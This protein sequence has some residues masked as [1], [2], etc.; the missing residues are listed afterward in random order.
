MSLANVPL[1]N[2]RAHSNGTAKES[3]EEWDTRLRE[4]KNNGEFHGDKLIADK[5]TDLSGLP[6]DLFKIFTLKNAP[7]IFKVAKKYFAGSGLDVSHQ[8]CMA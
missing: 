8:V 2:G 5:I 6:S 3:V 1:M 4:A 7:E